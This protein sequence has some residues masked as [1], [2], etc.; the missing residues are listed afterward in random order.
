MQSVSF[1]ESIKQFISTLRGENKSE[2][3]ITAYAA[4]IRQFV[5]WLRENTIIAT[6][7]QQVTKADVCEYL[8]ELAQRKNIGLTRARKLAAIREYFRYLVSIDLLVKSP[9]ESVPTPK[10]EKHSRN[11][12]SKAEYNQLLAQAG[13]N[14][15]D[16]AVLQLFLQTGL[17]VTELCSLKLDDVDLTERLLYVRLGKGRSARTIELEKKAMSALKAYLKLRS[18]INDP[19]LFL[20]KD[21][22]PFSRQG[23]AKLVKK[24]IKQAQITKRISVHSLRHTF[25]THKVNLGISPYR[26]QEWLGHTDPKT[27]Q[28]YVH[29]AHGNALREMEATSL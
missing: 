6:T 10:K 15:R 5:L 21:N 4:D 23:I 3:T 7:P 1:E 17:R 2:A 27:T 19:H 28:I 11:F 26:L 14:V 22:A 24:Y 16:F 25:A 12:L 9:A 18:A 8:A 29:L 13:G 20:S